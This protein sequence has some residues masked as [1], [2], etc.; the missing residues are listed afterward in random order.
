MPSVFWTG[1]LSRTMKFVVNFSNMMAWVTGNAR[2]TAAMKRRMKSG[3]EGTVTDYV[4]RYDDVGM[5][6]YTNIATELL[7]NVDVK[8]K[9]VVDVGCGT[10]ILSLAALDSGATKVVC[11]DLSEYMASQCQSKAKA[12]GY[13]IKQ[14][15]V[16][17]LDGES[18]P[19]EDNS[20][21]MAI[22]SMVMGFVPD[23][24]K[25]ITEMARVTRPGGIIAVATHGT[26]LYYEAVDAYFRA[27]SKRYVFGYR[28][29]FWP[30]NEKE[31]SRMLSQAGLND[32]RTRRLYYQ[33][34]FETASKA[35]DFFACVSG[36]WWLT[37]FPPEKIAIE[38]EKARRYFERKGVTKITEDAI[39]ALAMKP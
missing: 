30:R 22:S 2:N 4:T 19:F 13:G 3:Y 21:D 31:V 36:S 23:Q 35:Y 32:V 20:F 24:K 33:D 5:K 12:R 7:K 34:N 15:E 1:R 6:T 37:K 28:I 38:A 16:R 29:E 26:D 27:I 8:G 18:L 39:L 11:G 10:G 17:Q 9:N 14:I 25:F